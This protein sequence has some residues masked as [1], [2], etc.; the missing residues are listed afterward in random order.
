MKLIIFLMIMFTGNNVYALEN[1]HYYYTGKNP[2]NYIKYNDE[3]WRIMSYESD[4]TVKIIRNESIGT[5][6]W[7]VKN[8]NNW[9]K[10]SLN[11]YL[12]SLY[13]KEINDKDKKIIKF[14]KWELTN[15]NGTY[16][17]YYGKIG[18]IN[19]Y[20]YT[21]IS[22]KEECNNVDYLIGNQKLCSNY[23]YIGSKIND[24]NSIWTMGKIDKTVFNIS[25]NYLSNNETK[26]ELDVYPTLYLKKNIK[27]TG[28]G[29]KK[30]PYIIK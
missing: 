17:T 2:N 8:K 9:G 3:L 18:L 16:E 30:D 29:T 26:E 27:L 10:S 7:D 19:L 5:Y 14:H 23:N 21:R 13:Y 12:N 20:E 22:S 25:Y 1:S 6:S 11:D 15:N 28:K 24:N 4:G